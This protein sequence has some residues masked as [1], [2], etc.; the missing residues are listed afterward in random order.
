MSGKDERTTR[1]RARTLREKTANADWQ[2]FDS[3]TEEEI[4]AQVAAD[5]D[6]APLLDDEM[7]ERARWV[8]PPP[9]QAISLR[10][11]ADVLHWF[12]SRGPRYQSRI[13]RVLRAYVES[14]RRRNG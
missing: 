9:K 7:L 12:R 4:A 6:A 14:E 3:T 13:N 5:P 11:D 10:I 8:E 1:N 2:R